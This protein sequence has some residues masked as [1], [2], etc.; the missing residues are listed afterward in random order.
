MISASQVHPCR[1][2]EKVSRA[3]HVYSCSSSNRL[4]A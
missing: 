1:G 4:P 2:A 3:N